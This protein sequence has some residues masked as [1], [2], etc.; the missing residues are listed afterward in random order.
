MFPYECT[1][2]RVEKGSIF[3]I[4]DLGMGARMVWRM[5]KDAFRQAPNLTNKRN[6]FRARTTTSMTEN[7]S[8]IKHHALTEN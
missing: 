6:P 4:S 3:P 5:R 7:H 2:T 1:N 8:R